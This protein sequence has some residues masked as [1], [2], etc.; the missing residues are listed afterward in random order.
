MAG[1]DTVEMAKRI[2]DHHALDYN[3]KIGKHVKIVVDYKGNKQ[4][5]VC[6]GTTSDKRALQNFY[7]FIK[8]VLT[9]L[10]VNFLPD[11]KQLIYN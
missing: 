2:L 6:G 1:V 11:S 3:V 8:R 5:F 9:S 4:T 7:H 10:G